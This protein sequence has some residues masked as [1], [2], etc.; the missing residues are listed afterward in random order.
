M[1]KRSK[2]GLEL[3]AALKEALAYAKGEPN[4][5]I[6]HH[7]ATGIARKVIDASKHESPIKLSKEKPTPKKRKER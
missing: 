2:L 7:P 3:E 6:V 4:N 1:A 5:C